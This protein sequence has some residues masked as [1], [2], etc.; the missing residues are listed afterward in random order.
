MGPAAGRLRRRNEAFVRQGEWFFLPRPS[1][2]RVICE[3]VVEEIKLV[4]PTRTIRFDASGDLRGEWDPDRVEHVWHSDLG[5]ERGDAIDVAYRTDRLLDDRSYARFDIE[6]YA[7][8]AQRHNDVG[9]EDG[10]VLLNPSALS[11][12][13]E[14]ASGA[15]G[16]YPRLLWGRTPLYSRRHHSISTRYVQP[17]L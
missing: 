10:G 9:E 13:K 5:L 6:S 16:R 17:Q 8:R 2:M 14:S 15:G 3:E 1:D 11:G 12:A 4:Y 7:H